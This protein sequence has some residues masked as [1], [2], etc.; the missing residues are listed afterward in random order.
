MPTVS[1]NIPAYNQASPVTKAVDSVPG[2]TVIQR[3]NRSQHGF[4][5]ANPG[6]WIKY[7][8][9][10]ALKRYRQATWKSRALPDFIII[11]AMKS[12]TSSL[13]AYLSQH[14]QLL[15]SFAK[16][17][18]Y[19]DGGL[20]PG[21]DNFERG[22]AW[23]RA[24]FPRKKNT[25]PHKKTFEVSPLYIFNPL[26]PSRMFNLLPEVKM[27]VVLRN[28]TERAISHYFHEKRRN[29]EPLPILE[30][31]QEEERRL[32]PVIE[33]KD[34]KNNI[35]IHHS[36]KSRGLYKDQIERYLKF[37]SRSQMLVL[38]SEQFFAEPSHTLRQVFDFVGVDTGFMPKDLK[39]HNAARNRSAVDSEIHEYLNAYFR[40]HNQALYDMVGEDYGW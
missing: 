27:I 8:I 14:P 17:V 34:Y 9:R 19:F 1:V 33:S 24:H 2:Q 31:L 16:E 32:K 5:E 35:F 40:P 11:G 25:T 3:Q 37:F 21:I 15:P 28:P 10:S 39:S 6:K 23:Y 22:Q 4:F 12:G 29:V 30:A 13:Y 38:C 20:D 7:R 18:H 26:V 36:Y